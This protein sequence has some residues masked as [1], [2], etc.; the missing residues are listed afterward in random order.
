MEVDWRAERASFIG[1][2]DVSDGNP[3]EVYRPFVLVVEGI[4]SLSLPVS[5]AP[6]QDTGAFTVE[7][8]DRGWCGGFEG[9]PPDRTPAES[10]FPEAWVYSFFLHSLNDFITLQAYSAQLEWSGSPQ[11]R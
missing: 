8:G 9:W 7:L 5:L 2:A 4:R 1:W 3:P 10:P 11:S 6:Q